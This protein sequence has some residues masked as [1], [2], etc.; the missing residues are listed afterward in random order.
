MKKA[1][2]IDELKNLL[3]KKTLLLKS[4]FSSGWFCS[5]NDKVKI[6]QLDDTIV[7]KIPLIRFIKKIISGYPNAERNFNT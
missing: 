5:G 4:F 7:D 1:K 3:P 2:A 6:G